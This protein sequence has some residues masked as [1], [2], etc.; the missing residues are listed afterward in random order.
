M[1]KMTNPLD[2]TQFRRLRDSI[3]WAD[4]QLAYPRRKRVEGIKQFVGYHHVQDGA[5]KRVPTPFLKLAVTIYVRSLAARAPRALISTSESGFEPTAANLELAVNQI[6]AEIGLQDTLRRLVTEALF[7]SGWA[8]IGLHKVGELLGHEY[9]ESFVDV[10]TLDDLILDMTAKHFDQIQ[11]IGN[12]YWLDFEDVMES[13][14][15]PK[16][17]K[18]GLKHDEY[19]VIGLAGEDR[20]EGIAIDSSTEPFKEKIQLR[21]VWLPKERAMLTYAV[22]SERRLKTIDWNGPKLGPYHKLGFDDV[23]GNLLPLPP[24]AT[25]RDLHELGNALFRKLGDQADA[26]KTVP[27]FSGGNDESVKA[28]QGAKDGDG[29]AYQGAPPVNLKTGGVD[30]VTLA[31]WLQCRDLYSYF[32]SNLDSL[33]G[34]GPQAETL[35]QDKLISEASSAQLRDMATRVVDFSK[36]IFQSLAYYEWHDPVRRRILRKS[37]PGTKM[38]IITPWNRSSRRGKFDFYDLEIDVYSLQD[39][40][41]AIKLQKL[42]TILQEFIFPFMPAIEQ[43]GGTLDVQELFEIVAK[44]ADFEELK[45]LILWADQPAGQGSEAPGMPANTTRTY[46]RV[47]RPGAT[48]RGKSQILQQALLGGRPQESEMAA[49]GRRAG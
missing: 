4:T 49:L 26:Q 16:K 35:G 45:R 41:P 5:Q 3:N 24:V 30:Q 33:G 34:L 25:W 21:D 42:R 9:G 32:A 40:S 18:S 11:Y 17:A 15:F 1:A 27:A 14:W 13:D 12:S 7:S 31:F 10:V 28:F 6:P 48:D 8:K 38:S 46:E 20:A 37:I 29:I 19:T 47:N 43:N 36:D 39:D 44:Y 22:R 2:D 23:P